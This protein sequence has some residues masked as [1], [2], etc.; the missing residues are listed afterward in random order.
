MTTGMELEA[1]EE[2]PL[3]GARL[4]NTPARLP[5][6]LAR[7]LGFLRDQVALQAGRLA[8]WAPVAMGCGAAAYFALPREPLPLVAAVAL[9]TALALAFAA[10]RTGAVRP[11]A[12]ALSLAACALAGFGLAKVRALQV[13]APVALSDE[14]PERIEGWVV[15]V[16]GRGVGGPRILLAPIRI[17]DWPPE[18]TPIRVRLTLRDGTPI[19]APGEAVRVLAMINAPPPPASPGA[20]DFARDAWFESVGGIGFALGAP[21]PLDSAQPAPWRLRWAMAVNAARWTLA[22]AIVGDLGPRTGGLAA[23]MTT[24]HEAF[25]PPE[26]VADLRAA[27]LAHIISISGLHMAIVG[28]FAF[29]SARL[30]VAAWPWLALRVNGKKLAACVGLVAVL[31]YLALSGAPAPAERAAITAS[32]AFAAILAERQAISLHS[33]ALAALAILA[34]QPE[35]VI[36][37][38]F[39]M[40]FAATAALVALAEL[41]PR[42]VREIDV[43]WPVRAAQAAG[44]WIAASVAASFVAGLATGPFAM[45]HFNRVSTWGL[46][47]NLATAPISAFLMMPALAVGAALT[48]LGLGHAPLALAGFGIE[49]ML[50]AAH[51]AAVAPH[52]MLTVASAPAW[53]LPAA[54]LG[55]LWLCLWR[56]RLRWAGLPLAFAVNLAPRPPAPDAWAAADGAAVAVRRGEAAVLFRPDVK[57]F[58]AELWSRRRGLTPSVDEAPRDAL[59]ACDRWSCVPRPGAPSI[60]AVWSRRPVD[61][62]R[63]AALCAQAE[64][65]VVRGNADGRCPAALVLDAGDFARG[66]AVELRRTPTGWRAVW[67]QDL[68]GRR[69]WSWNWGL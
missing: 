9:A 62:A 6:S 23:A 39:Q 37:P 50:R 10:R 18:A 64:V 11:L 58:A 54:F 55:I 31:G 49:L 60:A 32:V 29:A 65:V 27:G 21:T 8:L 5:P 41:W 24:G 28:G 38:G 7:L 20:Y 2:A 52:A 51:A 15:D 47:A 48:P 44:A 4:L 63:L 34:L 69:P 1:A 46:A 59:Y 16:S 43:P 33:L 17:G 26:Q 14:R 30:A 36:E 61:A 19:P 67:A 53:A 66:G 56:G 42:P 12:L 35:A 25:I 68:R 40:S 57:R 45:Q 22:K 13:A 3:E